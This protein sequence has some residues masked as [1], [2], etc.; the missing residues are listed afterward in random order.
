MSGTGELGFW[1]AEESA[2]HLFL[3]VCKGSKRSVKFKSGT[4]IQV[5]RPVV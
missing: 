3:C 5:E 1:G 2:S 4:R